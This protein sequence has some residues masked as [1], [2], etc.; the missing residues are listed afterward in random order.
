[1][2]RHSVTL[3][4][5][6]NRCGITVDTPKTIY[7]FC[8]IVVC[9]V[10]QPDLIVKQPDLPTD[11][12]EDKDDKKWLR[13]TFGEFLSL[14][15]TAE[16]GSGLRFT[17]G[18]NLHGKDLWTGVH[19]VNLDFDLAYCNAL[20]VTCTSSC[21]KHNYS[22]HYYPQL[23][24]LVSRIQ[25]DGKSGVYNTT[26]KVHAR[27]DAEVFDRLGPNDYDI[28]AELDD[29]GFSDLSSDEEEGDEGL[30]WEEKEENEDEEK[31]DKDEEIV[32]S[33]DDD[34]DDDGLP[35][36]SFRRARST[37]TARFVYYDDVNE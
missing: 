8:I 27:V 29:G 34:D 37:R 9:I 5:L 14:P 10:K 22:M 7:I 33:G 4:D 28:G 19:H 17:I 13:E 1:M 36:P 6:C 15:L 3:R 20:F 35:G 18:H 2:I 24:K 12:E 26:M 21:L 30:E 32:Q 23:K 11:N 25:L 31:E 16:I